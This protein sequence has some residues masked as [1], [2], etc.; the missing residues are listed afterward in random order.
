MQLLLVGETVVKVSG[1]GKGGRN[2]EIA[3]SAADGIRN[4]GKCGG[5]LSVLMVQMGQLMQLERNS[6]WENS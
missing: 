5:F 6:E 2:Q 1:Q 3:L 4:P